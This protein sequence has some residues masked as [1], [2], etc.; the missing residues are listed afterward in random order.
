MAMDFLN[1]VAQPKKNDEFSLEELEKILG[2]NETWWQPSEPESQEQSQSWQS[3]ENVENNE[4]KEVEENKEEVNE[5]PEQ[6]NEENEEKKVEEEIE[7]EVEEK[8]EENNWEELDI[9][10]DD[11]LKKYEELL[12][13]KKELEIKYNILKDKYE[14][15]LEQYENQSSSK[16]SEIPAR[17][18]GVVLLYKNFENTNDE[19]VK[20]ELIDSLA[21]LLTELTGK[22]IF[23]YLSGKKDITALADVEGIEWEDM[24]WKKKQKNEDEDIE[25]IALE[26]YWLDI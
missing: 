23:S 7:K 12:T 16:Y 2:L 1:V 22:D 8:Q 14:K 21:S 9:L 20:N 4:E 10:N 26:M 18:K 17:M 3:V 25:R 24:S 19:K 15:L 13:E 5:Q 11:L 6:E